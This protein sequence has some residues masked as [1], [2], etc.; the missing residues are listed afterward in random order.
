MLRTL[1]GLQDGL[2]MLNDLEVARG[3]GQAMAEGGGKAAGDSEIEGVQ[4]AYAI[5]LAVGLRLR[6]SAELLHRAAKDY[7]ALMDI[8]PFWR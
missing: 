8:K 3:K 6:G 4:E 5:G 1:K 2:G 7:D